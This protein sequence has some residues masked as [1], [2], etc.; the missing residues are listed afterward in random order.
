MKGFIHP[1]SLTGGGSNAGFQRLEKQ[2]EKKYICSSLSVGDSE[3]TSRKTLTKLAFS[4]L[5][6]KQGLNVMLLV[7]SLLLHLNNSSPLN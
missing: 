6:C 2:R 3:E 7:S 1:H 4:T 5:V